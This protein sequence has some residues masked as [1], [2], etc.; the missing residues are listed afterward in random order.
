AV[1]TIVN[2]DGAMGYAPRASYDRIIATV[3]VWD[4]PLAWQRQLKPNGILVAPI[5]LESMQVSA[6]FVVQEDGSLYSHMNIPCGFIALRG[7]AAGPNVTQRISSSALVL[8]ANSISR[9][10][11]AAVHALLSED[12]EINHV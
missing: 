5:W 1:I 9:F 4:I 2:A 6:A 7:I 11:S 10:D 12:L 3:A 8:G